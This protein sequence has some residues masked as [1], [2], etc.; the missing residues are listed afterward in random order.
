MAIFKPFGYSAS[1]TILQICCFWTWLALLLGAHY[2][3]YSQSQQY[4]AEN[5]DEK[6][7]K[8]EA[9]FSDEA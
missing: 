7:D 1:R 2:Y 8:K 6:I 3:K 5:D 4:L 9:A